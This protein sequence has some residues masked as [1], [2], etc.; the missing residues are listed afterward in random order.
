MAF[1]ISD[2]AAPMPLM[3]KQ[4]YQAADDARTQ[5]KKVIVKKGG[6]NGLEEKST[7]MI[8][9][10]SG[11][12]NEDLVSLL[13]TLNQFKAWAEAKGLWATSAATDA[14]ELFT[15]WRKCLASLAEQK[16]NEVQER[17]A[18]QAAKTF[19]LFKRCVS[20]FIVKK[21]AHDEDAY[22]TQKE[23]MSEQRIPNGMT[24]HEYYDQLELYGSYLPLLLDRQQMLQYQAAFI[25]S[26]ARLQY[27]KEA[28]ADQL[29]WSVGTL[30]EQEQV[31]I[32]LHN[33]PEKWKI[34]F[35]MMGGNHRSSLE[36]VKEMMSTYD[37]FDRARN[38]HRY[39][40]EERPVM[41]GGARRNFQQPRH[42][43]NYYQQQPFYRGTRFQQPN[44]YYQSQPN[45]Q[46][47]YQNFNGQRAPTSAQ[48]NYQS[49][50]GGRTFNRGF[51]RFGQRTT[52]NFGQ[53]FGGNQYP[54]RGGG[55]RPEV[56]SS[57]NYYQE[58]QENVYN[59]RQ[60][61]THQPEISTDIDGGEIEDDEYFMEAYENEQDLCDEFNALMEVGYTFDDVPMERD[62]CLRR[63]RWNQYD[64]EEYIDEENGEW[65]MYS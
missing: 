49:R 35:A 32:I 51:G 26:Q 28:L 20:E 5:T 50:G 59:D 37:G 42:T 41:R 27:E 25:N 18:G 12:T 60:E 34:D 48:R 55:P 10:F 9:V 46:N 2:A 36:K 39:S 8:R 54:N 14:T 31:T 56:V 33:C 38:R 23:Y 57:Q 19:L 17:I 61:P 11:T 3:R 44:R 4:M 15:E 53:R 13:V 43:M 47:N 30:T 62:Q 6:Q 45:Y 63:D 58:E 65:N 24:F 21:I 16:W 29:L 1:Q 40:L 22:F 64:E 7:F 52:T